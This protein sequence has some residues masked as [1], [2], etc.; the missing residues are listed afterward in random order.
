MTP[1]VMIVINRLTHIVVVWKPGWE[2][3]ETERG[4]GREREIRF[5]DPRK[6]SPT[7]AKNGALKPKV[8]VF[9]VN[10]VGTPLPSFADNIFDSY[11]GAR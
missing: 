10:L 8:P 6:I 9:L 3:V 4:N 5:F 2:E 1:I 7:R 11:P